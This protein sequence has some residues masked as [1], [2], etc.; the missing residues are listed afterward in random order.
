[1][2][3]KCFFSLPAIGDQDLCAR[4]RLRKA[5]VW[6]FGAEEVLGRDE[7]NCGTWFLLHLSTMILF[8]WEEQ[9]GGRT[10]SWWDFGGEPVWPARAWALRG[11][12]VRPC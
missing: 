4:S 12:P 2:T 8:V 9:V 1:M 11:L 5:A 6:D 10:R 3:G 7:V